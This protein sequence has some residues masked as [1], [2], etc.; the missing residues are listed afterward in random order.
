MSAHDAVQSIESMA[1]AVAVIVT[2]SDGDAV[3]A[4]ILSDLVDICNTVGY[5]EE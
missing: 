3:K 1:R 5:G 2:D 4:V